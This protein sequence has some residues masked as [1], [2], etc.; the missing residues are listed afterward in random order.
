MAIGLPTIGHSDPETGMEVGVARH[1]TKRREWS[2]QDV[3]ELKG[4]AR[5]KTPATKI[6]RSLR[7]TVGAVRQK[8]FAMGVSLD[9]R[10]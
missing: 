1:S 8:A 5:Q 10:I 2:T 9:S 4:F 7:R 3:R 6:A